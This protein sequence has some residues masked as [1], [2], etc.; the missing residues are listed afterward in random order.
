MKIME[1]RSYVP[2]NLS[3]YVAP[4]LVAG[5][6]LLV[7]GC[8]TTGNNQKSNLD[9]KVVYGQKYNSYKGED[10]KKD[11]NSGWN[12]ASNFVGDLIFEGLLRALFRQ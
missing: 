4:A 3:R 5:G 8:A 7:S 1:M 6:L 2:R 11:N 9:N 12:G 10:I